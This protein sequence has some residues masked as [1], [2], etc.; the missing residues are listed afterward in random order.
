MHNELESAQNEIN[1]KNTELQT[2]QENLNNREAEQAKTVQERDAFEE[3]LSLANHNIETKEEELNALKEKMH[4]ELESAQNE[5]NS[6]NKQFEKKLKMI[7]K[8]SESNF[9]KAK[10]IEAYQHLKITYKDRLT[11]EFL[12]GSLKKD[13][14]NPFKQQA[15]VQKYKNDCISID[16]KFENVPR[17][18]LESFAAGRY[19]EANEDIIAAI[20]NNEFENA[21]EHFIFFGYDEVKRGERKLYDSIEL[22]NEENYLNQNNDV[23]QAVQ[24]GDFKSGYE[25]FLIFG[26]KELL[27]ST[28][29]NAVSNDS[30]K[31]ELKIIDHDNITISYNNVIKVPTFDKPLVSI[32]VPQYNQANYTMACIQ[33]IVDNTSTIPYEII[34]MDDKSPDEDARNLK[35]FIENITFISNDENLG[36]LLNCNKGARFAKGKY[37]LFLNND[38]NVQPNWLTSL[39]D[40]I[41]TDEKI[42]MVGSRLVYPDGRQQEAGG[43]VWN[44]ASGWNF[45]RLDDP[46]K[47][48]YNYVKEV[49]YIS[50]AAI[51]IRTSLWK[52]IGGFDERF[53]PAY[54]EDSDLAFE[55]RKHGYKVMYQPESIVVHFEGISHGT[56]LGSGIK[57]YQVT[58]KEKFIKKWKN[59]L[60]KKPNN[61]E[62]VFYARDRSSD[63]PTIL[64]IDHYVPHFD[65]D[66]G[67]RTVFG[68]IKLFI[69]ES[70][71]VKFIGD[72]FFPHQ[73]YTEA[74]Q[75]LGV[76]VLFGSWYANNWKAWFQEN[77][78][79][80]DYVFMNRPHITEKYIDY[81][82]GYTNAKIIYYGHDLHTLREKREY[83]LTGDVERLEA[84]EFWK[85]KEFD[86]MKKAD[87]SIY[88]SMTEIDEI[89]SIDPSVNVQTMPAYLFTDFIAVDR[90]ITKTSNI[91]FV[92]GFAHGPNVDAVLWFVNDVWPLIK[93]SLPNIKFYVIGSKPTDVIQALASN[94]IIVTGFVSDEELI[95]YYKTTRVA[96]VP[97]RY[98]AGIKGKVVEALYQQIPL[99]T[100]SVGAEGMAEAEK[101]MII[102]DDA[103]KFAEQAVSMYKNS[104]KLSS[105][106]LKGRSYCKEYFSYKAAKKALSNIIKFRSDN[107]N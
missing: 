87:M 69:S 91:M 84:A 37:I 75:Q 66:A 62:D 73:P 79:Y 40:L 59:E 49:D 93:Q 72:N 48:E 51:M 9:E 29:F 17:I 85:T 107:D 104:E 61:G 15:K 35:Y 16:R 26:I 101:Y 53:V 7:S 86:L 14:F 57:S 71:N 5:I 19:L 25:H 44:D 43:I 64:I 39:V 6:K 34:L 95:N 83:D 41:E 1:S 13:K 32:I 31:L 27:K 36:F 76:E 50:G 52:E 30:D 18:F 88:P 100:T 106:S 10:N 105:L 23:K 46:M 55:V 81:I 89:H 68:Y 90:D 74:L 58:N 47:P 54:Y 33:S 3:E 20:E 99:L 38:T 22:F 65:Q 67:S 12:K 42:G 78:K 94:D 98:G 97:L 82:G 56:D 8:N 77:G 96:V 103:Q 45:G 60:H 80:F 102:E 21:I 70:F 4:N 63:K 11:N 28:R 2:L 24:K 92:G